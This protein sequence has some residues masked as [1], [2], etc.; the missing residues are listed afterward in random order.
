MAKKIKSNM[1][2]K[3]K[4]NCLWNAIIPCYCLWGYAFWVNISSVGLVKVS[5]LSSVRGGVNFW[6]GR[7]LG[8]R[9]PPIFLK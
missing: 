4:A 7:G 3:S 5:I 1:R 8:W 6:T 9:L 2:A